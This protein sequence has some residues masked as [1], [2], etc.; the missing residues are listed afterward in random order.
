[1]QPLSYTFLL[2]V[3]PEGYPEEVKFSFQIHAH[4]LSIDFSY[5][6]APK[7]ILSSS[8]KS[9]LKWH[10][11]N[12]ERIILSV[13][14]CYWKDM[15]EQSKLQICQINLSPLLCPGIPAIPRTLILALCPN[16]ANHRCS[17]GDTD[18]PLL[19]SKRHCTPL[20][21]TDLKRHSP[22]GTQIFIWSLESC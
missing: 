16:K 4:L 13:K 12:N 15:P 3:W 22:T 2:Q 19:V 1:M 20:V 5:S 21:V 10:S 6:C 9:S 18:I 7:A 8:E 14:S 17:S 11:K